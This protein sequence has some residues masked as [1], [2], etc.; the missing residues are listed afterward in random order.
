[1]LQVIKF[2]NG[3]RSTGRTGVNDYSSRSHAVLQLELR[4]K[5]DIKTGR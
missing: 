5:N 2:G 4:D 3:V 1:M